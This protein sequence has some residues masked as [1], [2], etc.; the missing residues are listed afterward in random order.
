MIE[1]TRLLFHLGSK[2][3]EAPVLPSWTPGD[4]FEFARRKALA[5]EAGVR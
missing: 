2:V 3:A 1:D 5:E 4:E